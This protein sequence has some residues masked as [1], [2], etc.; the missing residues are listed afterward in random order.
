VQNPLSL[1]KTPPLSSP[2]Q[3]T[4]PTDSPIN[5]TPRKSKHR[6]DRTQ[7]NGLP[8]HWCGLNWHPTRDAFLIGHL[9]G[10]V[11]LF[12][13]GQVKL[14]ADVPRPMHVRLSKDGSG[15]ISIGEDGSIVTGTLDGQHTLHPEKVRSATQVVEG[16]HNQWLMPNYKPSLT[17]FNADGVASEIPN[18]RIGYSFMTADWT[19]SGTIIAS[20][21]SSFTMTEFVEMTVAG[22]IIRRRP[23][24]LGRVR[25]LSIGPANNQM[26]SCGE[27]DGAIECRDCE[28]GDL[29]W[30]AVRVSD[31]YVTFDKSGRPIHGSIDVVYD[32]FYCIVETIEGKFITMSVEEFRKSYPSR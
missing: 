11:S 21:A 5:E 10:S 31:D 19:G 4:Q 2:I 28:S 12:E 6:P 24:H 7:P 30:K 26:V 17:L 18:T 27:F 32:E 13:N 14:V 25:A 8:G 15:F 16:S 9:S 3:V 22:D 1:R 20:G 29:L 23:F